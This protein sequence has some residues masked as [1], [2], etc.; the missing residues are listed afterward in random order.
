[1]LPSAKGKFQ[2][3][4][5]PTINAPTKPSEEEEKDVFFLLLWN[6]VKKASMEIIM[7]DFNKQIGKDRITSY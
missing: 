1:M 2:N 6:H 3:L 4:S 5:L 7:G